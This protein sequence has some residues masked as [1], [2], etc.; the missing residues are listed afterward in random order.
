MMLIEDL[1]RGDAGRSGHHQCH[2]RSHTTQ[3]N[4][5]PILLLLRCRVLFIVKTLCSCNKK[6]F[7]VVWVQ[8]LY[9]PMVLQWSL[10][11]ATTTCSQQKVVT[12]EGWSLSEGES[13][14]KQHWVTWYQV[15][16]AKS[17]QGSQYKQ[18]R[19]PLIFSFWNQYFRV[20]YII[21]WNSVKSY[22]DWKFKQR[23][24]ILR[25]G[26]LLSLVPMKMFFF[27]YSDQI[28]MSLLGHDLM[29]LQQVTNLSNARQT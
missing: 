20:I 27:P 13:N 19:P 14:V 2:S 3:G 10:P 16:T 5:I 4:L 21:L 23:L 12:K 28:L 26:I 7:S 6:F 29:H 15:G 25:I 22:H 11:H 18:V 8:N 17:V 24:M 9:L 1:A